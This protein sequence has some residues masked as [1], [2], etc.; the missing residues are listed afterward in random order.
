[1]TSAR[2]LLAA[3]TVAASLAGVVPI[4]GHGSA[5]TSPSVSADRGATLVVP[6]GASV[7]TGL[8]TGSA[9]LAREVRMTV[10]RV[11]DGAT[12]FT[13]SLATFHALSVVPGTKL[14]VS[15]E[16]PQGARGA[17]GSSLSW[18]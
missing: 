8:P 16:R 7:L 11:S 2:A 6:K 13:G 14:L 9:R 4:V 17:A 12:H 10:V 18:S 15:V 1:V 5:A 3:G